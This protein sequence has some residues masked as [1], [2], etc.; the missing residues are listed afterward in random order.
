MAVFLF[1]RSKPFVARDIFGENTWSEIA[2][3]CQLNKVPATWLVGDYKMMTINGKSYQIDIIGKNHD[4]YSDGTGV[5]PLTFQLHDCYETQYKMNDTLTNVG[6][7]TDCAMRTTHLPAILAQMPAEVRENIRKVNKLTSAGNSS[8][9]ILTTADSLFLLAET[10]IFS[11]K[12]FSQEGEGTRYGYYQALYGA[13]K[14]LGGSSTSWWCRSPFGDVYS[15]CGV[16]NGGGARY[17]NA[18]YL[19][20]V[21]FAF[22]F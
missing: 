21:S 12:T 4:I 2:K 20:G 9:T 14:T 3:A 18:T 22:C 6:G 15:F 13:T 8:S 19:R 16:N 17:E 7:W 1:G 5:A 10:E 11:V